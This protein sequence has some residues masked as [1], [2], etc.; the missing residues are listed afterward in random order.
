M[1]DR[2]DIAAIVLAA[3]QSRRFGADKLLLPLTLDGVTLPLAAHSLLPWLD[4]FARVTVVV[5]PQ[6]E[7]L[8][9]ALAAALKDRAAALDWV[10]CAE[11]ERGMGH[12]LAA[13]I[14]A[15]PA[16]MGWLIGLA[17]MPLLP[18][19]AIVGVRDAL[20]GGARLAAPYHRGRRGHPVGFAAGYADE[21]LA[22]A[23]D[24]GARA[25]LQ[26]DAARTVRID[27][28]HG[29]IFADIDTPADLSLIKEN[30]R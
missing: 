13:G 16:A 9:T 14:A 25:L 18:P 5:R 20:A 30:T 24:A 10:V 19:S 12:S 11:A 26:R 4:V 29:G 28:D 6:A 2:R 21:L 23:G 1:P 27:S 22:L 7:A 3:G 8:C 17:D 15:R